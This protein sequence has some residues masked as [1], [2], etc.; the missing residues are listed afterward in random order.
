MAGLVV[1]GYLVSPNCASSM[2]RKI[3]PSAVGVVGGAV[4]VSQSEFARRAYAY[5]LNPRQNTVKQVLDSA[6][7][8]KATPPMLGIFNDIPCNEM[9]EDE[10]QCW[11]KAGFSWIVSDGEHSQLFGRMGRKQN[12]MINRCGMTPIQRLHRE[13]ISEHGDAMTLGARATMRPYGVHL[14]ETEQYFRAITYPVGDGT[15]TRDDRGGFPVRLGNRDM[16]FTPASLRAA[17]SETQGW[18]QFETAEY[19]LD[20]KKRNRLLDIMAAQ[21]KNKSAGFIGPFDAIMRS[22]PTEKMA[23]GINSLIKA[24]ADRGIAMGRVCGSGSCTDP[25]AIEDAMCEAIENGCRFICVHYMTS[26]LP[27][28]GAEAVAAPFFNACKRC[29]F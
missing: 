21:G 8:V 29:G 17:E 4:P 3:E 7:S 13:A 24:A 14:D 19:I 2:D 1:D 18:V 22:G 27:F 20:E 15:A 11:A 6:S 28:K 23:D 12:A 16:C 9:R 5:T 26:D 10:V 25:K